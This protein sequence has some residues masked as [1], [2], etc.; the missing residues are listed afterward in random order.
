[1]AQ[2]CRQRDWRARAERV[3]DSIADYTAEIERLEAEW[4]AT[5]VDLRAV[6]ELVLSGALEASGPRES[7]TP[8]EVLDPWQQIEQLRCALD[9]LAE[10]RQQL[11]HSMARATPERRAELDVNRW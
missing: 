8:E 5:V 6:Q 2:V 1:R 4:Q 11:S 3:L 7:E 10:E 9:Q